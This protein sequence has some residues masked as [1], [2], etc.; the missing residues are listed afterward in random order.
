M[1][2]E[3]EILKKHLGEVQGK[4]SFDAKTFGSQISDANDFIGA[5]QVLDL[6]LKKISKNI[7]ERCLDGIDE[8]QKRLLDAQSSQL[9]QNCSFMGENLFDNSF[10][11]NLASKIFSFEIQNPLLILENSDYEGVLAYIDDKREEISTLL[12]DLALA[13]EGDTQSINP[14]SDSNFDFKALFR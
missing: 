5:L 13:I 9:I 7:K 10:S 14:I 3:L 6:S 2:K 1:S 12:D 11:V 4:S 8:E